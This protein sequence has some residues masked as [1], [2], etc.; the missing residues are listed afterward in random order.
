MS[1]NTTNTTCSS[2]SSS[3]SSI[4]FRI[5][6]VGSHRVRVAKVVS[7]LLSTYSSSSSS[8]D[9]PNIKI[10]YIPCVATFDSYENEK[11]QT[12]KYLMK[13]EHH[14]NEGRTIRGSSLA[15]FFDEMYQ[16]EGD[17][18][19]GGNGNNDGNNGGIGDKG[20]ERVIPGLAAVAIGCGIETEEELEMISSFLDMLSSNPL[21][22]N[23]NDGSG[24]SDRDDMII[25]CI[26]PNAEFNTMAEEN[27]TYKSLDAQEKLKVTEL[28][29]MGPGKM[30]RFVH[31]LGQDVVEKY[32][33][34]EEMK[35]TSTNNDNTPN[36][37]AGNEA[38]TPGISN[39]EDQG[40]NSVGSE[41]CDGD[42]ICLEIKDAKNGSECNSNNI[43]PPAEEK[44][45]T[46]D[47]N[48]D[49]TV[50]RFACKICRSILFS[51][52][53]LED[54]P[55]IQSQHEFTSHKSRSASR[56]RCQSVF[57]ES[58]LDWMGDISASM[59]GKIVCYKCQSKLGMWKWAGGQC[60]CGTWVTPAIQ[61][62]LSRVDVIPPEDHTVSGEENTTAV[63]PPSSPLAA[64]HVAGTRQVL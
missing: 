25:K 54:P 61:V 47:Y 2:S 56:S 42:D 32:S 33:S 41:V 22:G 20:E 16:E 60:S 9:A 55:H 13:L 62:H 63:D 5:A 24:N 18:G 4:R 45:E 7:I 23:D 28:Q 36:T 21:N 51:E 58:G 35:A 1:C 39:A 48:Y 31:T 64:L 53:E 38:P 15:P 29:S 11:G 30:A 52:K 8:E 37:N 43:T 17:N 26:E 14:E 12:V 34:S 46:Q 27:K 50:T 6:I 40:T 49:A 57:L 10:E 59:E 44:C 19:G 3:S